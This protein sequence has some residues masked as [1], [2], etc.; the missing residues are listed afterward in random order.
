M[1]A[2]ARIDTVTN[3]HGQL[4]MYHCWQQWLKAQ[5]WDEL[6]AATEPPERL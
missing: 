1:A 2:L 6:R 5:S 4:W 3:E